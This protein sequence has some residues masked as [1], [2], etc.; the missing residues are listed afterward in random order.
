LVKVF[1]NRITSFTLFRQKKLKKIAYQFA[2]G[3]AFLL[4]SL[5][6][7]SEESGYLSYGVEEQELVVVNPIADSISIFFVSEGYEKVGEIGVGNFPVQALFNGS[8]ILVSNHLEGSVSILGRDTLSVKKTISVG[9][10]PYGLLKVGHLIF[11]ALEGESKIKILS[12]GDYGL[13]GDIFL[14]HPPR[15]IYQHGNEIFVTSLN[16]GVIQTINLD[17]FSVAEYS[18]GNKASLSESISFDDKAQLAFLP[19]TFKNFENLN[20]DFDTTLFPSIS[21]FDLPSKTNLR[22]RR[23]G[24]DVIDRPVGIPFDSKIINDKLYIVNAAS[25]DL[26]IVDLSDMSGSGYLKVGNNPRALIFIEKIN[27]IL[28]NN[29]LDG[30]VTVIDAEENVEKFVFPSTALDEE[31]LELV[32]QRL[33]NSSADTRLAKD[34]WI[35]CSSCHFD[36]GM[37]EKSWHFE[38]MLVN[39]PSLFGLGFTSPYHW[40]GDLDEPQDV[41]STIQGLQA[42]SGLSGGG[43]NCDPACD[44]APS[45][46][47]RSE[48]LDALAAYMETI[49]FPRIIGD[50]SEEIYAAGKDIF[51]RDDT[52][53]A[54]CHTPPI[55]MDGLEHAVANN[56]TA[57][58]TP[59]LLD[60]G[61]SSPYLHDGRA[62]DLNS[63]L[64]EIA[65]IGNHGSLS[66]VDSKARENLAYFLK[67]IEIQD[68][69]L[70]EKISA[71]VDSATSL[72]S[73][74]VES[75]N[76]HLN[77]SLKKEPNPDEIVLFQLAT[78]EG[79]KYWLSKKNSFT[80]DI[81][82]FEIG[83]DDTG[84]ITAPIK[85]IK[86][87]EYEI[88]LLVTSSREFTDPEGWTYL[89]S[90]RLFR[91][92]SGLEF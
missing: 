89:A 92:D 14:K 10:R 23:V 45:N 51:F 54:E 88:K 49:K 84:L 48:D 4:I 73:I 74:V 11:L 33:F 41:E 87:G 29:V 90:L 75:R 63:V 34:Q 24:L 22:S 7:I 31:S 8:E 79:R 72:N 82:Y 67:N 80:K 5:N 70:E 15:K 13:I 25:N 19:Q 6:V 58:N 57:I 61:R 21:I 68:K 62:K 65:D 32:G 12:S 83:A 59:S 55:Y 78:P 30:T 43:D 46:S 69:F 64:D 56:A 3:V 42:G 53:C 35:A 26:S 36:G 60:L 2:T 18:L 85:N 1:K 38:G 77:I 16:S 71:A 44:T 37:D 81:S 50:K 20:L 28:V 76:G 27:Q 66:G 39:T 91:S 52:G 9:S 47:G 40:L 17:N 86:E